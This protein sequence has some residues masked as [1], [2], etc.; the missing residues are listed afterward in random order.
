M[1]ERKIAAKSL[2]MLLDF[3]STKEGLRSVWNTKSDPMTFG[4]DASVPLG[5]AGENLTIQFMPGG[6][7]A[8]FSR[9]AN[10]RNVITI[11]HTKHI[12]SAEKGVLLL[13]EILLGRQG[14]FVHEFVHFLDYGSK[15]SKEVVMAGESEQEQYTHHSEVKAYVAQGLHDVEQMVENTP[16]AVVKQRFGT[17]GFKSFFAAAIK[18]FHPSLLKFASDQTKELI[19]VELEAIYQEFID[20][21][22]MNLEQLI[23]ESVEEAL[24]EKAP[25]GMEDMVLKLKKK[26][27]EK[28]PTPFKIAWA[29]YNKK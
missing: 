22:T 28:S 5:S 26:Y 12:P 18:L 20:E 21:K 13:R 29:Q 4:F 27:G 16:K 17:K 7:G 23:K 15:P 6:T 8:K 10:G 24:T 3:L 25:P 2:R 14:S 1:E 19:R 11:F 9:Q